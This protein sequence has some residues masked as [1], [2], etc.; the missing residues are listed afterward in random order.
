MNKLV[1]YAIAGRVPDDAI[2]DQY[3]EKHILSYVKDFGMK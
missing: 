2:P 3:Q 1:I